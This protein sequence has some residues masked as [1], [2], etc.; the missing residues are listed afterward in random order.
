M[1]NACNDFSC[2][3][4]TYPT[5][6]INFICV[7][8]YLSNFP[9]SLRKEIIPLAIKI[10]RVINALSLIHHIFP[11]IF[12]PYQPFP[13]L[14]VSLFTPVLSASPQL[15]EVIL[16]SFFMIW[17]TII[18]LISG[19]E[20]YRPF[21]RQKLQHFAGYYSRAFSSRIATPSVGAWWSP[22]LFYPFS[23]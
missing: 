23:T 5:P 8:F 19:L 4:E 10:L 14:I 6:Q 17:G 3:C 16:K 2:N 13:P 1:C 12:T 22:S 11:L 21:S 9:L 20:F 18:S 15:I 7:I